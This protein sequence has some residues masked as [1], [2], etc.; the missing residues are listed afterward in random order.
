MVFSLIENQNL[1]SID[2]IGLARIFHH[3][4]CGF[5]ILAVPALDFSSIRIP[6]TSTSRPAPSPNPVPVQ[7]IQNPRSEDDPAMIRDM[8]LANPDQLALLKQNN[9]RL[10]DALLSGNLRK[11]K[12]ILHCFSKDFKIFTYLFENYFQKFTKCSKIF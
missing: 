9:P 6:G 4:N 1:H 10:A 12:M 3:I 5:F 7:R 11:L 2:E 8:F